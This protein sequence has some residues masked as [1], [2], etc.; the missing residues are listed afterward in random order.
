[1][2]GRLQFEISQV[3]NLRYRDGEAPYG[4]SWP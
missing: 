2:D 4:S 3:A 1:M